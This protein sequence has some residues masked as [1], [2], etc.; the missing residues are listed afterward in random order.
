MDDK[1]AA[2]LPMKGHSERVKNKNIRNFNGTPLFYRILST[3]MRCAYVSGIYIDTDSDEIADMAKAH[4]KEVHIINRPKELCGDMV[5][6]NTIIRYDMDMIGAEYYIQTHATNPLLRVE[7]LDEGCRRFLDKRDVYDSLFS[8]NRLQT[9]LYDGDVKAVNHN[10]EEL[11]R[12]QDL[13]PLYE[14]NSNLYIFSKTSFLSNSARIGKKPQMLEMDRLESVD[15][16]EESDF[17][18]AEQIDILLK[19][20]RREK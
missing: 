7:T 3:L 4:F 18:L 2:L 10:P 1:F 14:E 19:N 16:D 9:R 20:E 17:M 8:V 12:T 6:M 15:I 5:S 13:P 11:V